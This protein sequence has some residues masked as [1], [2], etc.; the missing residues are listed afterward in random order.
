MGVN[1]IRIKDSGDRIND[2]QGGVQSNIPGRFGHCGGAGK[3]LAIIGHEW[4][5]SRSPDI[6]EGAVFRNQTAGIKLEI[7][8]IHR[9][10]DAHLFEVVDARNLFCLGF[11]LAQSR[12]QHGRQNGYDG[13][14]DQQL[15][16]GE[17][18]FEN[19]FGCFG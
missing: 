8:D 13:N 16:Q 6:Q 10:R 12:Q 18:S 3:C 1:G 4:Q 19:R 5:Q 15:N 2:A 17:S 7:A 14:D 11:G 9:E